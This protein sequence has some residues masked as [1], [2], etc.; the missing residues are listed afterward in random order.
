MGWLHTTSI[1]WASLPLTTSK[2]K[3]SQAPALPRL[4]KYIPCFLTKL[5]ANSKGRHPWHAVTSPCKGPGSSVVQSVLFQCHKKRRL[6]FP[7]HAKDIWSILWG[8]DFTAVGY[9]SLIF[10]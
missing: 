4:C 9:S 8:N 5:S 10:F 1:P 6:L 3:V 2:K 7:Q